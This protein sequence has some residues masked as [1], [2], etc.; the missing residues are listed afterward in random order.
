MRSRLVTQVMLSACKSVRGN[1]G[2]FHSRHDV[3]PWNPILK[4]LSWGRMSSWKSWDFRKF[5]KPLWLS[6]SNNINIECL[7]LILASIIVKYL[8]PHTHNRVQAFC[9][10]LYFP[11]LASQLIRWASLSLFTKVSRWEVRIP[12]SATLFGSSAVRLWIQVWEHSMRW[13]TQSA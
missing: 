2:S 6:K 11:H 12:S 13:S 9:S 10:T 8:L 7:L 4:V 5:W 3:R 1:L